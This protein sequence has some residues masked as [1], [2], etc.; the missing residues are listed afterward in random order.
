LPFGL[1]TETTLP[2]F[3]PII[4]FAIGDSLDI[5]LAK[6]SASLLPTIEYSSFYSS[7]TYSKVTLVPIDT[8]SV[9]TLVITT[10]FSIIASNSLILDST[11]A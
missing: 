1:S 3:K 7:S 9:S 6:G 10:A 11:I 4:A 2:T 5:L 8:T